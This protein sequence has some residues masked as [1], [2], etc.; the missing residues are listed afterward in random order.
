ML[1]VA[2]VSVQQTVMAMVVVT[3]QLHLATESKHPPLKQKGALPS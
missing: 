1:L 3:A 2:G